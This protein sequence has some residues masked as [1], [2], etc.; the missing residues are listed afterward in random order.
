[1]A[2]DQELLAAALPRY[3]IGE[4]IGRGGWGI[5]LSGRHREL[6]RRVAIKQLPRAFGADP[7]VRERFVHEARLVAGLDHPHIVP[8]FDFVEHEGLCVIVMELA[9]GGTLW[10]RFS[11][12]GVETD[13]AVAAV[14]ASAV[15]LHHAHEHG[16]LHRDVKPENVLYSASGTAKVAD[17][18]VAK[19]LGEEAASRTATGS[20]LG[21]AA[22]MA[23]EQVTG[24]ELSPRTDIYALGIILYELLTGA[25]PYRPVTE[26]VAQLF[27]HV[28][29]E[30][31]PMDD[32]LPGVHPSLE[33][34]ARHALEKD[35]AARPA[36]AEEF[37][38]ELATAA[39][40][41]LGP[42]WLGRGG[43]A[44]MSATAVVAATERPSQEV[45]PSDDASRR[46]GTVVVKAGQSHPRLGAVAS[47]GGASAG[48]VGPSG[49]A[50]PAP[51]VPS[52]PA[53]Q[54][55]PP[56]PPSPS[57]PPSPPASAPEPPG[58]TTG[59]P[60]RSRRWL[61]VAAIVVIVAL[62]GAAAVLL[63]DSG[64]D[65][66]QAESTSSTAEP[67]A[68][69]SAAEVRE[70]EDLCAANGVPGSRCECASERA[71]EE[72]TP[73][74]FRANLE[75]M[76]GEDGALTEAVTVIFEDCVDEES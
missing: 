40:D 7:S 74:Q 25:L 37:A 11:E 13:E 15:G 45:R 55:P 22:Y 19:A 50:P 64:G 46:A 39:T 5:V 8:V 1:M 53:G 12:R 44:V 14:L 66:E 63:S 16:I 38:V 67:V 59:T 3:E 9:S 43:H 47:S 48:T 10:D 6:G 65:A 41:A 18:G 34:V 54:S 27:Q 52:A 75:L 49:S 32:V 71:S 28:N 36:S 57:S 58:A 30:P 56:A 61:L 60:T 33:A 73:E 70:F 42:G 17:F 31:R 26:A 29:D 51:P 20:I 35:P 62:G 76:G 68:P 21:T 24:D 4:E 69:V 23:P 72:L 2:L